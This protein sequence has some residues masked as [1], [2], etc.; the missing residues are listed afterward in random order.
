MLSEIDD[1][2]HDH[3]PMMIKYYLIEIRNE[4]SFFYL[5]SYS[6]DPKLNYIDI[7]L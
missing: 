7:Y 1:V 2:M 3:N 6:L 4:M 5:H